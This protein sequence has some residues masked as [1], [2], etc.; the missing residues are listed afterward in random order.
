MIYTPQH[1]VDFA[2]GSGAYLLHIEIPTG[3]GKSRDVLSI[4]ENM[5]ADQW[6]MAK[7]LDE[8][9]KLSLLL[10]SLG[11]QEAQIETRN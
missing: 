4:D 1:V 10:K 11:L 3:S 7:L 2:Q 8:R 6:T 5:M 9:E